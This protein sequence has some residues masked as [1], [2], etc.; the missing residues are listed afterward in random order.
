MSVWHFLALAALVLAVAVIIP[1]CLE[2]RQIA[3]ARKA[4]REN[5]EAIEKLMK[6]DDE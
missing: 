6:D 3:H 2:L 1:T 4:A 5:W